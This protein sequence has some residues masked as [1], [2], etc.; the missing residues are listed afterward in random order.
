MSLFDAFL[1]KFLHLFICFPLF[2]CAFLVSL[3]FF[4][5]SFSAFLSPSLF[6]FFLPF[7][8]FS[9]PSFLFS[10]F[11][12]SSHFSLLFSFLFSFLSSTSGRSLSL[13]F[14]GRPA[15]FIRERRRLSSFCRWNRLYMQTDMPELPVWGRGPGRGARVRVARILKLRRRADR[16]RLLL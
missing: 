15:R 2:G 12:F 6:L 8:L 13:P 16:S 7:F 4:S 3:F 1:K 5:F 9:S 11:L 10:L 14:G